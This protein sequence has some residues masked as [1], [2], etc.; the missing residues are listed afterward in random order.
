ML[1]Q[2]SNYLDPQLSRIFVVNQ[3]EKSAGDAQNWENIYSV[4]VVG[5]WEIIDD[6][7]DDDPDDTNDEA[8][9][10]VGHEPHTTCR[11]PY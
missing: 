7:S 2:F 4:G 11:V 8:V 5:T 3:T 1:K 10:A 6:D 9:I